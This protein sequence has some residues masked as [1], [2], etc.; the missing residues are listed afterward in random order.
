M[1]LLANAPEAELRTRTSAKWTS[2]PADVL[3]LTV[4]EMDF[5]LAPPIAQTLHDAIARSDTGYIGSTVP[6]AEALAAFAASRW[7][8]QIDPAAVSPVA[9]VSVGMTELLRLTTEPGDRVAISPPVHPPFS[10]WAAETRTK[11]VEAP[12]ARDGGGWRL[13]LDAIERAFRAGARV[14]LLCH[15]HNPVGRVHSRD[16]LAALATLAA[17]HGALVL[18]DEIFGPLTLP[19]ADFVPFLAALAEAAETGIA[20]LSTGKAWNIAGLKCAT[21]VATGAATTRLVKQLPP[22]RGCVPATSASS[23][24]SPPTGTAR[25]G[26]TPRLPR[27]TS[28]VASSPSCSPHT[29]PRRATG[30]PRPATWPGLTCA[31]STSAPTRRRLSSPAPDSPSHPD[32]PSVPRVPG[33]SASTS[34]RAATSSP[35]QSGE[36]K[37]PPAKAT[38]LAPAPRPA[39]GRRER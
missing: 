35:T 24:P 23:P 28:A 4:A 12:L 13:D 7:G 3:P 21:V 6:L 17:E 31:N 36:S 39:P 19:G 29:C 26:S 14:Y 18:S 10:L 30:R 8:W 5:P 15:P 22:R 2:H 16:E 27:S 33:T 37:P 34:P 9:D 25:P 1:S 11:I 38:P 20:V 32:I